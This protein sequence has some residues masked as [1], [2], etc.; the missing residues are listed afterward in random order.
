MFVTAAMVQPPLIRP[1]APHGDGQTTPEEAERQI[2]F[3]TAVGK[4]AA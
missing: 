3:L 2:P 4:V 1:M